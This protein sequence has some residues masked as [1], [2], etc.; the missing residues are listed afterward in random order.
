MN[1]FMAWAEGKLY[2]SR[3]TKGFTL[4]LGLSKEFFRAKFK[5]APLTRMKIKTKAFGLSVRYRNK[6]MEIPT[7]PRT[8]IPARSEAKR[9]SIVSPSLRNRATVARIIESK[10]N[11][12][13]LKRCFDK[14]AKV[15]S[16]NM[17]QNSANMTWVMK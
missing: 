4:G 12:V 7:K 15:N 10:K 16:E 5:V 3:S 2:E 8:C 17:I 14:N 1:P 13:S 9:M 11:K 6:D